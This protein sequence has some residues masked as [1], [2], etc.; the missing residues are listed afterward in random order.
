LRCHSQDQQSPGLSKDPPNANQALMKH[1]PAEHF[2]GNVSQ[3]GW[4]QGLKYPVLL[5]VIDQELFSKAILQID[6]IL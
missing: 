6:N 1:R 4:I 2:Y 3:S 5:L